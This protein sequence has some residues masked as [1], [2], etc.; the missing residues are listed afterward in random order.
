M[1]S[2]G[3]SP[4]CYVLPSV[5]KATAGLSSL[6]TGVQVHCLA[7]VNGHHSDSLLLSSLVHFYLKCDRLMEARKVFDRIPRPNV[8]ACSALLSGYARKGCVEETKELLGEAVEMGLELN[9]VSWN[10]MIA[11]FNHSRHFKDSILMFRDM[12]S[13]G[14]K[15][16]GTS[17][18]SVLP[19]VGDLEMLPCGVQI[20]G[21]VIKQGLSQ[22]NWVVSSLVD[23]YGKCA[24]PNEMSKVCEELHEMDVGACNALITGLSRTGCVEGA[25]KRFKQ[26][27][28]QGLNLNV[29]SWTSM[30]A[31]CSQNGKD[32]EALELFREMQMEGLKPNSVTIPCLLPACGNIAALMHGK[33]VH[34]FSLKNWVSNDVYVGTA[35]IDM[36]ANCGRIQ[37]SRRCFDSMPRRNLVSWN[38]L[39]GG[40]AMHGKTKEALEVFNLM[41]KSGQ[42][43]DFISFTSVLSACSQGGLTEEGK[44]Y[45]DSM[46]KDY[47]IEPRLEHYS[48]MVSLLGRAGRIVEAYTMV[49]QMPMEPDGCIWGPL[50]SSCRVHH[51]LAIGEIAARK[52][53]ELEPNNPGNYVLLSNIYASKSMWVEVNSV[54]EMMKSKGLRKNPGCSWIEIKNKVHMLLAGD[55]LHPQ[56][57][58]ITKKLGELRVEMQKSGYLPHTDFVL[59]DVEEQDKEE[60]LCDH[61][62]KLAVA[63]GLLNTS[64][65]FP[66]QVIKN[67]R[68]CGD[69]H[70]V[71]KFI[72][73]FE[74]REIFVRDTNRFHHFKDGACSCGDL[75]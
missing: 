67:L 34:C 44:F 40:Y 3:I 75:W 48:C 13:E 2:Q 37:L 22:D 57:P 62:E 12:H 60:M 51:N 45:F 65:G 64:R 33:A 66:L 20:H 4:D 50:L 55:N 6:K 68:I 16:D 17:I 72:S 24:R 74:D 36:Y 58:E 10:G 32:M 29:V 53:F 31:S 30:I 26:F 42:E 35:L 9:S 1:L 14:F 73:E 63:L 71:I 38:A 25:L 47:G 15:P 7:F 27:K 46:S 61:S 11:G 28:R 5:V 18:S 52:L 49:K 41:Q 21:C 54:R 56:M 23:M 70:A 19:A 39:L 69:C 59:Q 8:V 43:P